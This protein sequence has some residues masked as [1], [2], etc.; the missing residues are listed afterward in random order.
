MNVVDPK[1]VWAYNNHIEIAVLMA[2]FYYETER[3][4][5]SLNRAGMEN[6]KA[7]NSL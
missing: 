5:K 2:S 1:P 3:L 6:V 4:L 7:G